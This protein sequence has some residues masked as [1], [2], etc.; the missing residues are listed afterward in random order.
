MLE[1]KNNE[2]GLFWAEEA[3][4]ARRRKKGMFSD[5]PPCFVKKGYI[6]VQMPTY[7]NK[8]LHVFSLVTTKRGINWFCSLLL[9]HKKGVIFVC[10]QV[11]VW[12][13]FWLSFS[14]MGTQICGELPPGEEVVY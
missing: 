5:E 11:L 7:F 12:V 3:R 14:S 1:Q 6:F 4:T 9:L 2:K 8:K 13:H 10:W